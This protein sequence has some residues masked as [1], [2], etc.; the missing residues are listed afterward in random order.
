MLYIIGSMEVGGAEQHLLNVSRQLVLHGWSCEVFALDP[1]GPLR[2]V[3]QSVGVPVIGVELSPAFIRVLAHPKLISRFRLFL[4]VP[5][6]IFYLWLK[7]PGIIHFFLPA[8]YVIGGVAS[9]LAM[10]R[11]RR[12]MSRRSLNLYQ[13]EHPFFR[14]VER[15]LHPRMDIICG[16]SVAVMRNLQDEGVPDKKLRLIYNGIDTLKFNSKISKY[17]KREEL[18][19]GEDA[20]VFVMVANLIEYK[21]HIDL[22]NALSEIDSSL[23]VNWVCLLVG[24]DDGIGEELRKASK[25]FEMADKVRYLGARSDVPALLKASDVGVLCSH[26]EGFS[27]AILEGMA[28]G[29]PMVVTDVGGN[30]EAVKQ[31]VNGLVVPSNSPHELGKALLCMVDGSLRAAMGRASEARA[32]ELY[33]LDACVESY[34]RM[35]LE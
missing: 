33:S 6:L 19:I 22:L 31:G 3:F 29:L 2:A 20:L 18:S 28:A 25:K 32:R 9:L 17:K 34:E 27:N 8:A 10:H 35:Y 11:P 4:A 24:R 7:R 14:R 21:G 5:K 15:W 16:N 30:A 12:F 13:L 26:E 23:P 1:D